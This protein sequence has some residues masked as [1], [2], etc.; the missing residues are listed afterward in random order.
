[1]FILLNKVHLHLVLSQGLS[2]SINLLCRYLCETNNSCTQ[3]SA[4]N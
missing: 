3:I 2:K 1:M 4:P